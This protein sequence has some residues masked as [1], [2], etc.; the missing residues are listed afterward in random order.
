MSLAT[1]NFLT[2]LNSTAGVK[3][4]PILYHHINQER[5]SLPSSSTP[6]DKKVVRCRFCFASKTPK[7]IV[8]RR[9]DS[10][11]KGSVKRVFLFCQICGKKMND[12]CSDLKPREKL[13]TAIGKANVKPTITPTPT[14]SDDTKVASKKKKK[15]DLNAGLIIPQSL[16]KN[17]SNKVNLNFAKN[18]AL[19]KMIKSSEEEKKDKLK[20]FLKC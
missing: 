11:S 6:A 15:K 19:L 16:V 3:N 13:K 20:S 4:N 10:T 17:N 12:R 14:N 7:F 2:S 1:I 18:A 9:R 8:K 5:K